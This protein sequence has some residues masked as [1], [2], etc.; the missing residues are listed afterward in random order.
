[1]ACGMCCGMNYM[2]G[3]NQFTALLTACA[4][5]AGAA[6]KSACNGS[7][8]MNMPPDPM[9]CQPC[10]QDASSGCPAYIMS[11]CTSTDCMDF[12]KCTMGCM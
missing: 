10:I 7:A 4:C 8:C 2:N 1:M 3:R 12:H 9:T 5:E 6:C 11:N